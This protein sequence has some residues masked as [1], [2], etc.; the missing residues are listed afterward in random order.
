[1]RSHEFLTRDAIIR[2]LETLNRKKRESSEKAPKNPTI[3]QRITLTEENK[4]RN[5]SNRG[6]LPEIRGLRRLHLTQQVL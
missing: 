1:M 6:I 2:A 3:E 5:Q 4:L